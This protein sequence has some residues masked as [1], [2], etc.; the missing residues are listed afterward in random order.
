MTQTPAGRQSALDPAR[1]A[2]ARGAWEEARDGFREALRA[3]PSGEA[4]EGLA[5]AL[6]YLNDVAALDAYEH[7]FRLY[8]EAGDAPGAARCALLLVRDVAEFRGDLAVANG[9]MR[10]ARSIL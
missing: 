9:W 5:V 2:L 10:R 4:W 8:R 6:A 7:G 1:A 3:T